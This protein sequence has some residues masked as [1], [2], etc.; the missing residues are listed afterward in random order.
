M[1]QPRPHGT[2]G[3]ASEEDAAA[4]ELLARRLTN[5]KTLSGLDSLRMVRTLP[6][7]AEVM[8]T[9]AG[10]VFKVIIQ[11]LHGERENDRDDPETAL[12]S[13]PALFSGVVKRAIVRPGE[14]VTIDLTEQAR[15]RLSGY[16]KVSNAGPQAPAVQ[17]R[18]TLQRFR[19]GYNLRVTEFAPVVIGSTLFTQ[20]VSQ[21]PTWYSGAMAEVV[22]VVG[23]YGRQDFRSLPQERLERARMLLPENV[24]HRI[25]A[26]LGAALLPGY[27]GRPPESGE[28]Q[29]DY[30][31]NGTNGI[32]F[33]SEKKPWLL[34]IGEQGVFAMPL[35][36]IPA[37]TTAAFK[38]YIEDQG[39]Q[40][41]L[42]VLDRFGGMPSGE[43]MP[44]I[45]KDFE[46]WRRAGVIIKVCSTADFYSHHM[47]AYSCGWAFN[48][49]GTEAFNT[50][51]GH[52]AGKQIDYGLAYKLS[53]GL[54]KAKYDGRLPSEFDLLDQQEGRQVNA[55]LSALSSRLFRE[56][57][58]G[59]AVRY[60]LR[61]SLS[62]IRMRANGVANSNR[63]DID[64]EF[65][66]WNDLEA[67]PIADHAGAVVQ[68]SKGWL[69]RAN[70]L[71]K[72]EIKFPSV[73]LRGCVSHDFPLIPADASGAQMPRCDTIM[74]GYYIGDS[75]KVVKYFYDGRVFDEEEKSSFEE[76]MV[77]GAWDKTVTSGGAT[78]EGNFYTSDFDERATTSPT[79]SETSVVGTDLGYDDPPRFVYDHPFSTTGTLWRQRFAKHKARSL[80][81]RGVYRRVAICIPYVDRS[82]ALHAD[83]GGFSGNSS[84]E[85]VDLLAVSD[86]HSYRYYTFDSALAWVSGD[87]SGNVATAVDGSPAP[88]DGSPVWVKGH[89]YT[90]GMCRDFADQGG[91]IKG[92]PADYTWL[93]HPDKNVWKQ[94]G[95]GSTPSITEYAKTA[96]GASG[97]RRKLRIS[98]PAQGTAVSE[99][100][101]DGYFSTS[102]DV[103][104]IFFVDTS[105]V[106]AGSA[107]YANLSE[108]DTESPQQRKRWGFTRLADHKSAHHFIGVIN[109]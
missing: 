50:C 105:R 97:E 53:L 76:C 19:I 25:D 13:I 23:G 12:R 62:L 82:A 70:P 7:G 10:G 104:G 3:A 99:S 14:G 66:Y 9:D 55:Y 39:D 100:P 1:H 34:R 91:W 87:P 43:G 27:S 85:S 5:I 69:Y 106:V 58:Q 72:P 57:E 109:E 4:A 75:L 64:T 15:K 46:A 22:Q 59:A 84:T 48:S 37:T 92:L 26:E 42:W 107:V 6:S 103:T 94:N 56:N 40:E 80:T 60:K 81:T 8:A 44:V 93:V 95:G 30:K 21:R 90:P 88:K 20:Y 67:A 36:M 61:R 102:P 17:S 31:F 74:Y 79:V 65:N 38:E 86:P 2:F 77:V 16:P 71:H 73:Q 24:W 68:T 51:T 49:S 47:Y 28:F 41:L 52:D 11:P 54:G 45:T 96:T 33:D 18:V 78:I 29:Y 83:I 101:N 108:A 35:P 63:F 32:G 98:F 89:S